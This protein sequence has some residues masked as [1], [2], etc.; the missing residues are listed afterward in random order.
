MN[1]SISSVHQKINFRTISDDVNDIYKIGINGE[2]QQILTSKGDLYVR[3]SNKYGQLGTNESRFYDSELIPN[4]LIKNGYITSN[5]YANKHCFVYTMNNK[6]Y[7]F[8]DTRCLQLGL[9]S[10]D[11]ISY[12]Y[13]IEYKFD[14]SITSI[15]C[16][17]DHTIFLTSNG[18]VYGC[19]SNKYGSISF[20]NKRNYG[21][22]LILSS[23]M[24]I[25]NIGCT[26]HAS[27]L[28]TS[29]GIIYCFGAKYGDLNKEHETLRN[30]KILDKYKSI[31]S[32]NTGYQHIICLA[33]NNDDNIVCL[34]SLGFNRYFQCGIGKP[35]EFL[36]VLTKV[37]I[38]DD[39]II[40]DIKSGAHHN[41]I[42]DNNGNYYS[43]GWNFNNQCLFDS[44]QFIEI[45]T[46]ISMKNIYHG[47]KSKDQIVNIIP[48]YSETYIF[49]YRNH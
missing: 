5:G 28:L 9:V 8:G 30:V 43:F 2:S 23:N 1:T 49:Q 36:K 22:K 4:K 38:N 40:N 42:K 13:L 31:I 44:R 26:K 35:N 39:I 18:C 29:T 10:D 24:N 37:I 48:G 19:G 6:L 3:G 33:K 7:G 27:Y 20:T 25:I 41:V 45:P 47:L 11:L 14:S 34:R 21:I 15:S 46:K 12:P 17:A 32:F 16:G